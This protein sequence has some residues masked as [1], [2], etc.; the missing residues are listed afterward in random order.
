MCATKRLS[1]TQEKIL[2]TIWETGKPVT[3]QEIVKKI[4][5]KARSLNMHLFNLRR[6]GLVKMSGRGYVITEEGKE[7]IVLPKINKEMAEKNLSKRPLIEPRTNRDFECLQTFN[8]GAVVIEDKVHFLYRAVGRDYISRFGYANSKDGFH[9]DERL[10]DPVYQH[11]VTHTSFYSYVSGG[12][13][14]GVEDPR[15]VRID[16]TVYVTYTVCD[17]SLSVALASIKVDDFL[18]KRWSQA[19]VRIISPRGETHKNWVLFPK[20]IRG[21]YAVLHSIS[22]RILINYLDDLEFKGESFIKSHYNGEPSGEWKG[23]WEGWVKGVGPPPIETNYGWLVFYHALPKDNLSGYCIGSMLLDIDNP[24]SI[25]FRTKEPILTPWDIRDGVKP[26]IV[27]TCGAVV[28]D[29]RLLIYYG[30]ADTKV[31]VAHANLDEFLE[32]LTRKS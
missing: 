5:L 23:G 11:K 2:K 24:T 17:D 21:K 22:P 4:V 12:S 19:R 26:N 28:K 18:S 32:N 8:T 3:T 10:D 1:E 9:L 20:K 7:R 15:I 16:D 14:G 6:A 31:C 30:A 29:G 27:Y 25:R 13:L